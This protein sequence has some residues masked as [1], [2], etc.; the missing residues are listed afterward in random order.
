M[1]IVDGPVKPE[2][3]KE[4]GFFHHR[5]PDEGYVGGPAA[6]SVSATTLGC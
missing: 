2:A 1:G 6:A 4:M 5:E 3:A